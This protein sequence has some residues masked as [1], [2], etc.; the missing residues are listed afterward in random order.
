MTNLERLLGPELFASLS[1]AAGGTRVVVPGGLEPSPALKALEKRFGEGITALLVFHFGGEIVYIPRNNIRRR[2][3]DIL[4]AKKTRA[5]K[6]ASKI[7]R[8]LGCSDRAVYLS[9][10]RCRSIGLLRD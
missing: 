9:R 5:G 7:A 10:S 8:E 1:R 3:D 2:V 4:V 6:S